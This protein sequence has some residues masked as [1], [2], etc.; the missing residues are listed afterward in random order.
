[1]SNLIKHLYI[2]IPFCKS[3]CPYCD[4]YSISSAD[5]QTK[6]EYTNSLIKELEHHAAKLATP[7]TSLYLGGG[8]PVMLGPDNLSTLLK[9]LS[10]YIDANTEATIEL[11][12]EHL[13]LGSTKHELIKLLKEHKINRVS[14]GVQTIN[15]KIKKLI[16][17]KYSLEKLIVLCDFLKK[18]NFNVSF[19]FMFGLPNQTPSILQD[20]LDFIKECL[21]HHVS[22]Y[23]F[24]PPENYSLI[25]LL[26]EEETIEQMFSMTHN[27]MIELGYVQYEISNYSMPEKESV[28]NMAYWK[29]A[30]YLGLGAAAHSFLEHQHLRTWHTKDVKAYIA[31]PI[32]IVSEKLTKE[33]EYT[34]TIMLGLRTFNIGVPEKIFNDDKYKRMLNDGLLEKRDNNIFVPYE[35]IVI[36]D[37][38]IKELT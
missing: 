19:D 26:P 31:N 4:F 13:E 21:P 17:R 38:I 10:K 2:H 18:E 29:R 12:P 32:D 20:D 24:T 33:M 3:K 30:S 22:M 16:S 34:E 36:L 28:H 14:I 6:N 35:H 9:R 15:S 25:D 7:L 5:Q 37:S 27:K 1:M 8:S 11:N 23:L